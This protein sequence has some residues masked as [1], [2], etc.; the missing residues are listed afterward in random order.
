MT[1]KGQILVSKSCCAFVLQNPL[2]IPTSL[3][4]F[5]HASFIKINFTLYFMKWNLSFCEDDLTDS[6]SSFI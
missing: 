4:K 6:V 1:D 2:I 5:V 3:H